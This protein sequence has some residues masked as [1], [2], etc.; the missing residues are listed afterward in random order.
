MGKDQG[1]YRINHDMLENSPWFQRETTIF[2]QDICMSQVFRY[3]NSF[4]LPSKTG[5]TLP[6]N[7][8]LLQFFIHFDSTS[9][10]TLF[11]T[12]LQKVG[13]WFPKVLNPNR[14]SL[15]RQVS[16]YVAGALSWWKSSRPLCSTTWLSYL[17]GHRWENGVFFLCGVNRYDLDETWFFPSKAYVYIIYYMIYT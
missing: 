15:I 1:K 4:V 9:S 13:G 8:Y 12:Y 14:W 11:W 2:P 7:P 5:L 16:L 3:W 6:T 17:R 10:T